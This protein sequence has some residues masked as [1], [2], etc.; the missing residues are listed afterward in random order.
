VTN[1]LPDGDLRPATRNRQRAELIAIADNE[2]ST[3][4]R[5]RHLVPLAA[6]AAIVLVA[7]LAV[8]V[9]ALRHDQEPAPAVD[10]TVKTAVEPLGAAE[11]ARFGRRCL[12][13]Y[14]MATSLNNAVL[15][16]VRAVNPPTDAYATAWVAAYGAGTWIHCAFN[17]AGAIVSGG[18]AEPE[19]GQYDV[20]RSIG[21]G[22]GA[23]LKS[24]AR[25]TV[26]PYDH[27]PVEA[28][29]RHGFYYA[30][31]SSVT[32]PGAKSGSTPRPYVVRGYDADGNLVYTGP[33][34][35]EEAEAIY[36]VC[37]ADPTGKKYVWT[38]EVKPVPAPRDCHRGLS[39]S[40]LPN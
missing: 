37:Y 10:P 24:V 16:G 4:K 1:I 17:Q 15:D 23:Y 9:P 8:V 14:S 22:N 36:A 38:G 6:A 12:L 25:I 21:P 34:T 7:A 11:K 18:G 27:E 19:V 30:P 28:V 31:V 33:E 3:P 35:E 20:V 40:W 39:W 5:R 2:S 29:L 26:T 32:I 13:S